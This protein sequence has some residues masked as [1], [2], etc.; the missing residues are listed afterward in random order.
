M[1][2]LA[3]GNYA[4]WSNPD[5]RKF[6]KDV[7]GD[8]TEIDPRAMVEEVKALVGTVSMAKQAALNRMA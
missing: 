5:P 6:R 7:A 2:E 1:T 8:Y 3:S 4:R